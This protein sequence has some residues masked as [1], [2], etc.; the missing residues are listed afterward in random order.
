MTTVE[1]GRGKS[2]RRAYPLDESAIAPSGRT[3]APEEVSVAWQIDAYRF[4][5]PLVA[6]PMDSV[7]SPAFAAR[8]GSPR[9]A[10]GVAPVRAGGPVGGPGTDPGRDRRAPP[11]G[12]H[13][14]A[15]ADLPRAHQGRA[16]RPADRGDPLGRR[17]PRG[18]AVAASGR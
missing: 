5:M 17:E 11:G 3:R 12:R 8:L 13:P 14:A 6:S 10:G 7:V 1:I 16:D 18:A 9:G 15:P 2:G 4:E